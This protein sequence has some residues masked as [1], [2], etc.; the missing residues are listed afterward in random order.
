MITE[1]SKSSEELATCMKR[2]HLVMGCIEKVC[3][4]PVPDRSRPGLYILF[5]CIII[6]YVHVDGE[7]VI[8][9]HKDNIIIIET[10]SDINCLRVIEQQ[11]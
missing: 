7:K 10:C 8:V 1:R 5:I 6:K 3:G 4:C 9:R 11:S 2:L